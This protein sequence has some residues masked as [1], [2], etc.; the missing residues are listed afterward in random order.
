MIPTFRALGL[1]LLLGTAGLA[2]VVA[3]NSEGAAAPASPGANRTAKDDLR[4]S[5]EITGSAKPTADPQAGGQ[6][7]PGSGIKAD[8]Q[9]RT[10]RSPPQPNR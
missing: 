5:D 7:V 1:A 10:P 6:T 9:E 3:Q 8:P 2:P 4:T